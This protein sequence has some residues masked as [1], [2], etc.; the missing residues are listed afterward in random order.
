MNFANIMWKHLSTY[1]N[2]NPKNEQS[3]YLNHVPSISNWSFVI[4]FRKFEQNNCLYFYSD[5]SQWTRLVDMPR[6]CF[7]YLISGKG[8]LRLGFYPKIHLFTQKK[9]LKTKKTNKVCWRPKKA[10]LLENVIVRT[11]FS[12]FSCMFL[13]HNN[14][15]QF[16]F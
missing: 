8:S 5:I 10:K 12:N 1:S 3:L 14:F 11:L 16:E 15:F 7:Q 13:N 6:N 9:S 2:G 4:V